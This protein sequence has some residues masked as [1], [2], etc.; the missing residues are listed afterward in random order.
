MLPTSWLSDKFS[1]VRKSSDVSSRGISPE[2]WLEDRSK[3]SNWLRFP[4]RDG[5]MPVSELCEMLSP[6]SKTSSPTASGM[7]PAWMGCA[8]VRRKDLRRHHPPRRTFR[9]R[10][11]ALC[12]QPPQ[13]VGAADLAFLLLEV[14]DLAGAA[15]FHRCLASKMFISLAVVESELGCGSVFHVSW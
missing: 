11:R 9:R 4:S 3:A 14:H 13:R 12:L 10:V 8:S 6:C 15:L 1:A 2:S 5:I 7:P